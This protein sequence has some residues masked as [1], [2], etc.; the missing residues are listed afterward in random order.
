MKYQITGP[1]TLMNTLVKKNK[2]NNSQSS[3]ISQTTNIFLKSHEIVKL[4]LYIFQYVSF[5]NMPPLISAQASDYTVFL[6]EIFMI[7]CQLHICITVEV[8]KLDCLRSL[9][10]SASN[11]HSRKCVTLLK[12]MTELTLEKKIEHLFP[13][14][15][16]KRTLHCHHT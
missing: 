1:F 8:P 12:L 13:D 10:T 4:E 14:N 7:T 16:F 6:S 2:T 3:Q 5:F 9:D 15:F 11:R